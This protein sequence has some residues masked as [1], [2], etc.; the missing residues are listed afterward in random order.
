MGAK[1]TF[2]ATSGQRIPEVEVWRIPS[3]IG[4]FRGE[5][6]STEV[7]SSRI[8]LLLSILVLK[9]LKSIIGMSRSTKRVG[10]LDADLL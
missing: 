8:P 10:L 5:A 7:V 1:V 6:C 4:G 3:G 2:A 9:A